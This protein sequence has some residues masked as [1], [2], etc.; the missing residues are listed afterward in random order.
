MKKISMLL[1][2][3]IAFNLAPLLAKAMSDLEKTKTSAFKSFLEIKNLDI[4][5]P[6]VIEFPIERISP[7]RKEFAVY[8]VLSGSFQ[9]YLLKKGSEPQIQLSASATSD[10]C[11]K[12]SDNDYQTYCE[13]PLPSD[14][15]G[16]VSIIMEAK[17]EIT[18]SRLHLALDKH[19]ALPTNVEIK[20]DG[21]IVYAKS[22]VFSSTI[23]FP[24]SSASVWEIN[25]NYSQ[26]LRI[27][28]LRLV[29][30][31]QNENETEKL[32]FLARPGSSYRVYLDPSS[33]SDIKLDTGESADLNNNQ[34]ILITSSGPL[35]ENPYFRESD[36]D[37]DG[38]IDMLDNCVNFPNP[39][40]VDLDGNGRGDACDDFDK[41][42]II[43][44]LDNC[45]NHPNRNQIDTDGDGIGDVC[46]N[47]ESRLS[48]KYPYLPWL[49]LG[50]TAIIIAVLFVL[51]IK[52]KNKINRE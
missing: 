32:R 30:K 43:N 42:G 34:N 31:S 41:D 46:D 13:Y 5:V 8:E 40:Q 24:E 15:N 38:I 45:P 6:T 36:I 47:E 18:S 35:M 17:E 33:Y 7:Q 49:S 20:A 14:G 48:E 51:T 21:K 50:L 19:V 23:L 44:A 11:T 10:S 39:D 3:F 25:F 4:K 9:P 1:L 16:Q 29:Q 22:K 26:L 27:S 37:G 52:S 28:E 12:I 2:L